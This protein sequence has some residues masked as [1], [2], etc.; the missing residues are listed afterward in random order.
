MLVSTLSVCAQLLYKKPENR[1]N[2]SY[3]TQYYFN[4][5]YIETDRMVP[6]PISTNNTLGYNFELAYQR[7]T[8]WGLIITYGIQYGYQQHDVYINYD[9]TNFDDEAKLSLAGQTYSREYHLDFKYVNQRLMLGYAHALP[10]KRFKGWV[11]EIKG[12]IAIKTFSTGYQDGEIVHIDYSLDKSNSSKFTPLSRTWVKMGNISPDGSGKNKW[13]T[14]QGNNS[15][16]H[17]WEGCINFRKELN[18]RHL[19]NIAIGLEYTVS[20]YKG[21]NND[22]V[23]VLSYYKEGGD[24]FSSDYY[25]NYNKSIGLRL[26][27]GLW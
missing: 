27:V 19:K 24:A 18:K 11:A 9:L 4:N 8:S 12:G 7:T 26:G 22:Y 14:R 15:F 17:T 25:L 2:I 5:S 6:N 20:M 16:Y 13:S 1:I 3:T 10:Q 23:N 21:S